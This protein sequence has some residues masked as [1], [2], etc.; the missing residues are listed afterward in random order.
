LPQEHP[1]TAGRRKK[2]PLI[3]SR[4]YPDRPVLGVGALIFDAQN[5]ILLAQRGGEPLKGWWSLPGGVLETGETLV[6]GVRREVLEETGLLVEP[7]RLFEVFER[8]MR[9]DEGRAEYH[10]VLMDYIC[11]VTGGTLA[12]ADDC[13]DVRWVC[14]EELSSLYITEGT[15]GVIDK[16]YDSQK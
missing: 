14:R 1:F 4:K 12:P 16:A 11:R 13:A 5:R 6:E 3:S 10:Y 7:V 8:I 2:E 9:D 15:L